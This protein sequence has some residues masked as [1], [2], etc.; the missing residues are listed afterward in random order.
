M[1]FGQAK[2]SMQF[3]CKVMRASKISYPTLGCNA[4]LA[5]AKLPTW[6]RLPKQIHSLSVCK[7]CTYASPSMKTKT[8]RSNANQY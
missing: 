3:V 4:F 5:S 8:L 2:Q 7:H 6:G 1:Q